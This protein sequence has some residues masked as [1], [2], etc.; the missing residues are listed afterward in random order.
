MQK[1]VDSRG[2]NQLEHREP[3]EPSINK[4]ILQRKSDDQNET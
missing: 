3:F 4:E 1:Q 2:T